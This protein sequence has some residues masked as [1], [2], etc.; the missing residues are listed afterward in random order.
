[1][2]LLEQQ[3]AAPPPTLV[4]LVPVAILPEEIGVTTLVVLSAVGVVLTVRLLHLPWW[5]LLFPPFL[6]AV[7]SG[8][9]QGMLVP[10]ILLG[11]GPVAALLKVYA[12]VPL[13][14]TLRWRALI[15]TAVLLI[16]TAPL[17]PWASYVEH[18]GEL[19]ASLARQSQGGLS[20]TAL[21]ILVPVAI[22]VL[23]L[24][25][26]E[27]AAWLAVPTI[28]PATQWYYSTLAVP[29]IAA[30]PLAAALMALNIPGIAVLAAA[31]V[32]WQLRLFTPARLRE[33]W[34]PVGILGRP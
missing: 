13:A 4:P 22:V 30:H 5:W 6:D 27:K 34:V 26:R 8:N 16:A 25:G 17:L 33:A 18:F 31:V 11:A 12:V 23:F 10:L 14:L 15:V 28:W 32:A 19:S 20:A 7:V 9:P 24:C 21:P 3:F 2:V 29:A 1:M